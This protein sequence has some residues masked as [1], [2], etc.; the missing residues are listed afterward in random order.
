MFRH[1]FIYMVNLFASLSDMTVMINILQEVIKILF[2][3]MLK[4][5][6]LHWFHD[7]ESE[8]NNSLNDHFN[9]PRASG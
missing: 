1:N 7:D 4:V 9:E 3:K 2:E 6:N 8:K 5:R